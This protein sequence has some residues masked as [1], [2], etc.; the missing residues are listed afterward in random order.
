MIS[1]KDEQRKI[2]ENMIGILE[3]AEQE[4]LF[5]KYKKDM[6]VSE[7]NNHLMTQDYLKSIKANIKNDRFNTE[8]LKLYFSGKKIY[9]TNVKI[10]KS[11]EK[12]VIFYGDSNLSEKINVFD[13][14]VNSIDTQAVNLRE[15]C[16]KKYS[17]KKSEERF[18]K[19]NVVLL[20]IEILSGISLFN[21]ENITTLFKVYFN[22]ELH[23]NEKFFKKLHTQFQLQQKRSYYKKIIIQRLDKT[24]FLFKPNITVTLKHTYFSLMPEN[25]YF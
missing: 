20:V 5:R 16:E 2:I 25:R 1:S 22:L 7:L 19:E 15:E 18:T 9:G 6:Y 10:Q 12:L 14:V 4:K 17:H 23:V 13:W 21:D 3:I 24:F 11:I 8:A